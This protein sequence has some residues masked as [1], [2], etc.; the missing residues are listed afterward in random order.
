MRAASAHTEVDTMTEL[1]N[2][3]DIENLREMMPDFLE[4]RFGITDLR[5]SFLCP[6]PD[7]DDRNPSCKYYPDS[8]TIFCHGCRKGGDVF[9]VKGIVDGIDGFPDQIRGV[10]ED[11]G[12]RLS[13]SDAP[14]KPRKKRKKRPLFDEPREA[15]GGDCYE[16]CGNAF[17]SIYLPENVEGRRY[18]FRRGLDD[19]DISRWG[20]GFTRAPKEIMPEFRVSEK[21]AI[22]Y[23]TIPFWNAGFT[24]ARYCMLRTVSKSEV[25]NKEWRPAGITSPLWNEWM[26]TAS[27]DVVMV[28]EGPIDAIALHKLTKGDKNCMALGGVAGAKR[29]CQILYH[30]DP[31]TRPG[32]LVVCMDQDKA[33]KDTRDKLSADLCKIGVPH[34]CVPA[35]PGGAKDPDDWL[36]AGKGTEWEFCEIPSSIEDGPKLYG[37]RWFDG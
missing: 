25:R 14:P 24:E 16:A 2:E 18:L 15:G 6:F 12:Y 5:R 34:I 20:L 19:Q 28:A 30:A 29:L 4:A 21:E 33:G 17:A 23:I 37:T 35:Y 27:L 8:N 36:M 7:H 10:A 9:K 22:G 11:V 3:R 32:V 13:D 26:L 1:I 31:R